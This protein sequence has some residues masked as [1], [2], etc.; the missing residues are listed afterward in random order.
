M[1]RVFQVTT[2]AATGF[3]ALFAMS[4]AHAHCFVG[5]RFFP[6]TLAVDDPCVADELSLPTVSVTK[7]GDDPSAREID[8]SAEYSKRITQDFGISVG[9]TFT[10][11]RVPGGASSSGFQNLETIFKYQ[12]V[13]DPVAEFVLS[14]GVSTEWAHTGRAAVGAEQFNTWTPT[15]WFGK[16]FG[17]LPPAFSW[18]RA[19]AVTGQFGY[20]IP[21]WK[22]TVT[23]SANIDPGDPD[24]GI[25]PQV[26]L[27]SDEEQHAR[28]LVWGGTLQYNLRYLQSQVVDIGL[29][30]MIARLI[31]I[32]E[33]QFQTPVGFR[34]TSGHRTTGTVNPG[35]IWVGNYFQLGAEAIIPINQKSG[36][37]VGWMV[38]IHFYL[39]DMFPTSIGKPMLPITLPTTIGQP[40][41]MAVSTGEVI[42]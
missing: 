35:F 34:A 29:P 28:F 7:T 25:S 39:D 6:A 33:V 31:P 2:A 21:A 1:T 38:Q 12:F 17:D 9:R 37:G 5:S 32:T 23:W 22:R 15:V 18:V 36:R 11:L 3:A 19:F 16:G 10:R 4:Q 27:N 26:T 42:Q 24:S 20:Q 14:T 8:I 40:T 13:T 41:T 30:D